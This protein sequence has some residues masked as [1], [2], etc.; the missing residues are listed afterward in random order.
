MMPRMYRS[1]LFTNARRHRTSRAA[2]IALSLALSILVFSGSGALRAA[3]TEGGDKSLY[4][5]A[6]TRFNADDFD[7]SIIQLKNVLQQNPADIAARI[8]IG[9]AYL[10]LGN[11]AAAEKELRRALVEGGDEELLIVPLASATYLLER[12][13]EI[14]EKFSPERRSREVEAGL[15]IVRGQ[16]YLAQLELEKAENPSNARQR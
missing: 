6:L 8:L 5:D 10:R 7:G 11:A 16:A 9:K 4:E 12:Y 13:D 1:A 3:P 15:R 2:W 14:I